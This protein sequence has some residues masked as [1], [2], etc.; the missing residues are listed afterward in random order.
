MAA[1]VKSSGKVLDLG[2]FAGASTLH[3]LKGECKA[4]RLP[5]LTPD[6]F[7]R[8]LEAKSFTSRNADLLTVQALYRHA[9]E[10]RLGSATELWLRQLG[11]ADADCALLCAV[12]ASGVLHA[13]L[14]VSN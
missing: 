14:T 1:L 4:G 11:W 8:Q 10:T 7:N 5:P 13:A 3:D 12:I 9:Y 6:E 2:R